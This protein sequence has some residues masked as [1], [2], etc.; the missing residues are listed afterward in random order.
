MFAQIHFCRDILV[1][2]TAKEFEPIV[3]AIVNGDLLFARI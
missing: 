1:A 2:E 3:G